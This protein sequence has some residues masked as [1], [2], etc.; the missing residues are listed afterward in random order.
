VGMTG[1]GPRAA[2]TA[3]AARRRAWEPSAVPLGDDAA[4]QEALAVVDDGRLAR[5]H[6][7]L[8]HVE[9][10]LE[11]VAVQEPQR[12][13]LRR[14]AVAHLGHNALRQLALLAEEVASLR[15]QA[16]PVAHLLRAHDD[17][18]G[19]GPELDHVALEV[20][21]LEPQALALADR[22]PG[23]AVVPPGHSKAVGGVED[24]AGLGRER[25]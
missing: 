8:R 16:R 4:A 23:D 21:A 13:R 22:E 24:V 25:V 14:L 1:V 10:E 19:V 9:R 7:E 12:G 17:L 15:D 3:G 6:G 5:R 2:W 11:A 20:R 18:V